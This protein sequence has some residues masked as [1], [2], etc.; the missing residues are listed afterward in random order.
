MG[1][2]TL[3][4][5]WTGSGPR[6]VVPTPDRIHFGASHADDDDERERREDDEEEHLSVRLT[7]GL[8]D[9]RV[10]GDARTVSLIPSYE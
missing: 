7:V 8:I 4:G 9:C 2:L 6:S 5:T 10:K 1:S 3:M